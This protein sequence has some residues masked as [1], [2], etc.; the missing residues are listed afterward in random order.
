MDSLI[1][2]VCAEN[3]MLYPPGIPILMKG[4]RL[5]EKHVQELEML[6]K[7]VGLSS[8]RTIVSSDPTLNTIQVFQKIN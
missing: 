6:R 3:I 8:G 7:G 1:D 4:E 5:L 2:R